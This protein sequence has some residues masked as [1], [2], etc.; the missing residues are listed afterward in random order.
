MLFSGTVTTVYGRLVLRDLVECVEA[1]FTTTTVTT[2]I[3]TIMTFTIMMHNHARM[4]IASS[5]SEI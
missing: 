4:M 1:L 5:A 3:T 2:A